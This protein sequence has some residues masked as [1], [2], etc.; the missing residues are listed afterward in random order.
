MVNG[1]ENGAFPRLIRGSTMVHYNK[2][3]P[4]RKFLVKPRMVH[5]AQRMSVGYIQRA[6][7]AQQRV[8]G[9]CNVG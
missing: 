3:V 9:D 2:G 6:L 5:E 8:M 1:A 4:A 7:D